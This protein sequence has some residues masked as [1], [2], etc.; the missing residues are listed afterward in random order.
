M[1][2]LP[3]LFG[4]SPAVSSVQQKQD[5]ILDS[6]RQILDSLKEIRQDQFNF[7]KTTQ[8]TLNRQ[9]QEQALQYRV[10][11]NGQER[12]QSN[13]NSLFNDQRFIIVQIDELKRRLSNALRERLFQ[14][15]P[16]R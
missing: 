5:T 9:H 14:G 8:E 2:I 16:T 11:A 15:Q 3:A 12:L 13:Q 1:S 4:P 7:R 6:Q 10:L